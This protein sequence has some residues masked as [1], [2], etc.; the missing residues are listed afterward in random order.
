MRVADRESEIE[1]IRRECL[2]RKR[3]RYFCRKL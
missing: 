3:W 1:L 2:D